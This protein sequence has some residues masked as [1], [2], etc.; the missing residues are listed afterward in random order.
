MLVENRKNRTRPM[1]TASAWKATFTSWPQGIP[2]RGIVLSLLNESIP[3]KG[4]MIKDDS[5]LLERVNPDSLGA[6]FILI[7][8]ESINSVRFTDPIK[9]S[10]LTGAGFTG[11]LSQQ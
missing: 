1:S 3:F 6:R 2:R 11:K 8:F 5:L 9:E 10:V 7:G 4:F